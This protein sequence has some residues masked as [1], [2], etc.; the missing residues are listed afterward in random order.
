MLIRAQQRMKH[1]AD[2]HRSEHSFSMGDQIYLKLQ[3]YVQTS[4]ANRT[5]QKLSFR[6]FG[7]FTVL[8]CIGNAAYKLDLP[9]DAKIHPVVHVSQLKHHIPPAAEVNPD[10]TSIS[11]DPLELLT[12]EKV[13]AVRLVKKGASTIKQ[14]LVKWSFLPQELATWEEETDHHRR[15][16]SS[17]A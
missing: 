7:P 11:T 17:S 6:F 10:L 8:Q 13:L 12:P 14:L 3:P 9:A 5:N 1:Q 16:P 2:K 4:V 15:F